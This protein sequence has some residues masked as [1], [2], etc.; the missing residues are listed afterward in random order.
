MTL[1]TAEWLEGHALSSLYCTQ[2]RG[3]CTN[4][5]S[6]QFRHELTLVNFERIYIQPIS[7]WLTIHK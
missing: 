3:K 1:E 5:I 6:L 4:A 7:T 2:G